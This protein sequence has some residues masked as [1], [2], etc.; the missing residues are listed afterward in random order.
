MKLFA[1]IMWA[2]TLSTLG[3]ARRTT[4]TNALGINTG[5]WMAGDTIILQNGVWTN[6]AISLRA[7]GTAT[8]PIVLMAETPGAVIFNGSSR[9]SISGQH[10]EISGI[11]FNSGTLSGL[12]VVEFRTSSTLFAE[13]SRL[14]NS[15]IIDYNPALNTIDSKWISLYG[16]NNRVDN[17]TF[18]NK[19]NS[20]TLMVVW[21]TPGIVPSHLIENNYFGFRNPNR[22]S[23]GNILNGQEIIRVGDSGTSMQ[24]AN[25]TIRNNF[26][27][28]CNGETEIISNKSGG[29]VYS[30][31]V[32]LES[33]GTLTLRH[34]NNCI[35]EGNYFFGNGVASTGGV[36][37]IGENHTVFNNYFE[38]LR[39]T[40]FRAALCI[41]RGMLNSALNDYFQVKNAQVMFNTFVNCTQSFVINFNS[42]AS[43]TMPPIGTVIA[44]NHVFNTNTNNTNVFISLSPP[45]MEITWKNNLMNAGRFNSFAPTTSQIITGENPFMVTVPT[46]IEIMEPTA[47]SALQH[48]RTNEFNIV[49]HDIRGRLRE[50]SNK[51]PGASEM[52]GTVTREMPTRTNTGASFL[53]NI[54]NVPTISATHA[55]IKISKATDRI[56]FLAKQ[57]GVM[58]CIHI[59][60]QVLTKKNLNAFESF[61]LSLTNGIYIVR[62]TT[63]N[64]KIF[65]QK[66]SF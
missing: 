33:Q 7:F 60:G 56:H 30:N 13:H 8:Q 19:N 9:I 48:F 54:T 15:A 22:D 37:I 45:T 2:L 11:F 44:H 38:N 6:Q 59:N 41:V 32:F 64:Q 65:T 18:I 35:V 17:C 20:G 66:I 23:Q 28:R 31:N 21:L 43:Y 29:N 62:F 52:I 47:Q 61:E 40:N 51:T 39:G 58:Q 27:E 53:R 25:C 14:T 34:G 57:A 1:F 10:I 16:R 55:P 3:F 12:P 63:A 36:R 49:T 42:S 4:T 5:S 26:F 24:M 50:D 46:S